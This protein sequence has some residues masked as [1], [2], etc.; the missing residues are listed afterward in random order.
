MLSERSKMSVDRICIITTRI[1]D[2]G[3][4][5]LLNLIKVIT[6]TTSRDILVLSSSNFKDFFHSL[7]MKDFENTK[8]EIESIGKKNR[9]GLLISL[10]QYYLA[11]F[12]IVLKLVSRGNEY[13]TVLFFIG[14]EKMI[15]PLIV[16]KILNKKTAILLAGSEKKVELLR[17]K[18]I[19]FVVGFISEIVKRLVDNILIYSPN[20]IKEWNLYKYIN[21]II[22]A[23]EHCIEFEC[24]L[25]KIANR[26]YIGFI[27]R[28]SSEK[29]IDKFLKAVEIIEQK[30]QN[31][32]YLFIVAGD[33]DLRGLT[34]RFA[35]KLERLEYLGWID[36]NKLCEL[37]SQLKLLVLPSYTEGLPNI[38]LEAMN[39]KTP[40]IVTSV[41]TIPD[42]IAHN[43]T[44]YVLRSNDPN[45]LS[46]VIENLAYEPAKLR[47]ISH[48]AYI[49]VK[50]KFNTHFVAKRWERVLYQLN[51]S[52]ESG[53]HHQGE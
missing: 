40:V 50:N 9:E 8:I 14:G 42:I 28:L 35:E 46:K 23:Y 34:E 45:L 4:T 11:Q 30:N 19:G 5:P 41:G 13:N 21:K 24:D 1:G 53:R 37:L 26:K 38:V 44:G 51:T 33:G 2:A 27:G 36:K 47:K 48:N 3:F 22:F 18:I 52:K 6:A 39:C 16:A 10:L 29:G 32:K 31:F 43:K 25:T 15:F 17:N 20:L 7:K 12:K 49:M